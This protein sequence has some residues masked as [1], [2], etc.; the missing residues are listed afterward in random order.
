MK[1]YILNSATLL[2]FSIAVIMSSCKKGPDFTTYTYPKETTTSMSPS[3][4]FA[5]SYVTI[6]GNNFGTLS[7]AVKVYFGG[8]LATNV[9][10][11]NDQI[12]VQVPSNG[13]SGKVS[14]SVW[15][16]TI[17]S[18]GTYSVLLYPVLASVISKGSIAPIIAA[19]GDT[20]LLKGS[21]F[22]TDASKV[23]VNFNGTPVTKIVSLTDTLITVIAPLGYTT[24]YVTATF[25]GLTLTG[26]ALSPT[27]PKGDISS[28]Y[29]KN[30][31]QPF[32][33]SMMAS[34]Q[35]GASG[36][37]AT[38]DYW[39]VNSAGQNQINTG[40]TVRCGGLNYGNTTSGQLC[41]QAGWG[42]ATGNTLQNA[43]MYQTVSLPAGNYSLVTNISDFGFV[44]GSTNY[45]V[46]ASGSTLPDID[47]VPASSLVYT[48]FSTSSS[49]S[50]T[51]VTLK[52]TLAQ[53][54]TV[55]IGFVSTQIPNSWF[56]VAS[57]Q[58]NLL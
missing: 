4:G 47:N 42:D 39:T 44:S 30:Y 52:F 53:P 27:L 17:D 50:T 45:I 54:T 51:S 21:N 37:W 16:N 24:G 13:V 34:T 56:R 40:A 58:L 12:V 48:D 1:K 23:S 29:L 57:V 36:N 2:L 28:L 19:P 20:V 33:K 32:T 55:S 7:G 26:T 18:V 43:K 9:S 6:K 31:K 5:T 22:L 11:V 15:T 14:L 41:F 10:V 35:I 49:G 25:N 3:S 8:I 38:P 46:V